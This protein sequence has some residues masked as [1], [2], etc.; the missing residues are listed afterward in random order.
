MDVK[1]HCL[2]SLDA[3]PYKPEHSQKIAEMNARHAIMVQEHETAE[4]LYRRC[5]ETY[6]DFKT[7]YAAFIKARAIQLQ[8]TAD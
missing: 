7:G 3:I 2:A 1:Q 6:P 5:M 8:P 4:Q